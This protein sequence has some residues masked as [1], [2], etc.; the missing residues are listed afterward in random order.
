VTVQVYFHDYMEVDPATSWTGLCPPLAG[1]TYTDI[2]T[3]SVSG[4]KSL[5]DYARPDVVI[6]VNNVPVLSL[7][8]TRGNPSGHNIPQRFSCGVRASEFLVPSILYYPLY[9]RRTLS[10]PNPRWVN[11]RV[12]LA[13]F[14][15]SDIYQVPALSIFWPTDPT[16]L[17]PVT[18]QQ[19]QQ[20]MADVAADLI[21]NAGRRLRLPRLPTVVTALADMEAAAT[22]LAS[23]Q[24]KNPNVR[25]LLPNG[26]GPEARTGL[27]V[28]PTSGSVL[29]K[30]DDYLASLESRATIV[31]PEWTLNRD[32]FSQRDLSLVFRGTANASRTDSEHPWPGSLTMLDMLYTRRDG[33]LSPTARDHNLVYELGVDATVFQSRLNRNQPPRATSSIPLPTFW[34]W[35]LA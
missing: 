29:W 34:S 12:L 35:P 33:G 1:A 31:G 15:M 18:G 21:T 11:P 28:D 13:Q 25:S 26:F 30:T 20:Q 10:D 5:F 2:T 17:L 6:T 9:S 7:E 3:A 4:V 23:R 27:T 16:T 8:Q 14:R 24:S 32:D 19:A 22:T